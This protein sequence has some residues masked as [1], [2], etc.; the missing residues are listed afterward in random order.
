MMRPR[1]IWFQALVA[2]TRLSQRRIRERR[3]DR[4]SELWGENVFLD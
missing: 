2:Q 4:L 1:S 3:G